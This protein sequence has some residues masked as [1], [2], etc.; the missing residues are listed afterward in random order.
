[1]DVTHRF[2]RVG[3]G[4]VVSRLLDGLGRGPTPAARTVE[5]SIGRLVLIAASAALLGGV[6]EGLT[7]W[8]REGR[9]YPLPQILWVAPLFNLVLYL[10][11]GLLLFPLL[12]AARRRVDPELATLVLFGWLIVLGIVLRWNELHPAA[13]IVLSLGVTVQLWRFLSRRPPPTHLALRRQLLGLAGLT[14]VVGVLGTA[15]GSR[16]PLPGIAPL[17]ATA[18]GLEGLLS[19]NLTRRAVAPGALTGTSA[20]TPN[21]MIV[22]LDTVGANHLTHYGYERPTSLKY[23]SFAEQGV[24]F[25]H[26]IAPASWTLPSHATFFTGRQ[27]HEHGAW[28]QGLD[29]TYPTLAEFLYEEGFATA[30]FSANTNYADSSHGVARGFEVFQDFFS[31]PVDAASRT[32]VGDL[33]AKNLSSVGYYNIAGRKSAAEVNREFTGWLG[34]HSGRKFFAFLNYFDAHGPYFPPYPYDRWFTDT[35][36][37]VHLINNILIED[38]WEIRTPGKTEVAFEVASYDGAIAYMDAQL[39]ELVASLRASGVLD[40]TLMIVLSDHGESFVAHELHGKKYF[41]HGHTL[42]RDLLRVPLSIRYP[43]DVPAGRRISC[44][45]AL[46]DL[47]NTVLG[48]INPSHESPFPGRGLQRHW[49]DHAPDATCEDELVLSENISGDRVAVK[50]SVMNSKWHFI[51][52]GD[53]KNELYRIDH[54]PLEQ[55]DVSRTAEGEQAR[56]ELRERMGTLMTPDEWRRFERFTELHR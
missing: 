50:K 15:F 28:R 32:S 48:F 42:Y 1:M 34:A 22:V 47:P 29:D 7:V 13:V 46:L 37:S 3:R 16:R 21:V 4:R 27:V 6:V 30:G 24:T 56:E 35:P 41:G 36:S 2:K 17:G 51:I 39:G 49:V 19:V 45:I 23:A 12:R 5:F 18:L 55:V 43:R 8:I 33:V 53:R 11:I 14:V 38:D 10:A 26:A 54:D 52:N 31:N 9:G 20:T 40:D 25:D 44:P